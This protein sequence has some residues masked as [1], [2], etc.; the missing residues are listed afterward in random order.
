MERC[1]ELQNGLFASTFTKLFPGTFSPVT[2]F[3]PAEVSFRR[4]SPPPPAAQQVDIRP[5]LDQRVS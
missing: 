5:H 1:R 4:V 2:L 3:P